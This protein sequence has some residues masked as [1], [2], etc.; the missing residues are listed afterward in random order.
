MHW[1]H[2]CTYHPVKIGSNAPQS[3]YSRYHPV[4]YSVITV[5]YGILYHRY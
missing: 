4:R 3:A 5:R 2:Q 1:P